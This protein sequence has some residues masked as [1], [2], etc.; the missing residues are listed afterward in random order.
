[1]KG[2]LEA[3]TFYELSELSS[4]EKTRRL[5]TPGTPWAGRAE[6]GIEAEQGGEQAAT[7]H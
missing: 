6:A 4:V 7:V 3:V 1:M 2:L 5:V